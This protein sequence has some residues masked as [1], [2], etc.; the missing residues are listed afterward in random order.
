[1]KSTLKRRAQQQAAK[2]RFEV[3]S[4]SLADLE[5]VLVSQPEAEQ[6]LYAKELLECFSPFARSIANRRWL[7]YSWREIA[8]S[9][10]MDHTVVRRAY[11]REVEALLNELSRSRGGRK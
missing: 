3:Q 1:M 9:L 10:E 8:D 7:G 11:F 6:Q 2:R 5:N 4:G